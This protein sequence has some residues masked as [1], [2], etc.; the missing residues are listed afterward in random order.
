MKRSLSGRRRRRTG[1]NLH[2]NRRRPL[3]KRNRRSSWFSITPESE[4]YCYGE[5]LRGVEK[6][7]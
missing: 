2:R 3:P 5:R 6:Q 7:G 4:R 1:R